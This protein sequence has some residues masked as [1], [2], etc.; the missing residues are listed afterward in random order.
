MGKRKEIDVSGESKKAKKPVKY[1]ESNIEVLKGLEVVRAKPGMYM[2]ERG[3]P[4]VYRS[5]KEI[6][7]NCFD[8]FAAGRNKLIEVIFDTN[9]NVYYVADQAGGIPVGMHKTEKKSA[10]EVIFTQLHAGGKF[11][12]KAYKTSSGTHG[13]GAAATNALS[14]EFQVWTQRE[15]QWYTQAYA[16]GIPQH[17]VK[18]CKAPKIVHDGH[19]LDD[20]IGKYGSIVRFVPDQTIVSESATDKKSKNLVTAKLNMKGA[21]VWL[22]NLALLNP[23]L[24]IRV[25]A[26]G[27]KTRKFTFLNKEGLPAIVKKIAEENELSLTG[28]P[29]VYQSETIDCVLQWSSHTDNDLLKTYVNC[30]PTRDHGKHFDGLSS[31]LNKSLNEYKGARDKFKIVDVLNGV[32]GS[33]NYKMSGAEYSSQTKD[34]LTSL[35]NKEIEEELLPHLSAY[36][37]ANKTMVKGIIKR[38]NEINKGRAQ[39]KDVMAAIAGVKKG[40]SKN[41]DINLSAFLT[42]ASR[43]KPHERELY[44]VEGDSAAGPSKEARD[45]KF[46]EVFKL[47]GKMA[48][49]IRT[50]L[51]K[52]ISSKAIILLL[53]AIGVDTRKID[54]EQD[55]SK[56]HF[57]TDKLRVGK[58]MLLADADVD[59]K[60]IN[61][62]LLCL[63]WRLVPDAIREGRV[64]IVDAPLYSA[65]YNNVRYFGATFDAVSKQMPDRAP[66]NIISRAKGWG[67]IDSE[68]LRFVA[69][70]PKNRK[71]IKIMPPKDGDGESYFKSIMGEN[72]QVRKEL[73]GIAA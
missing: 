37:E 44:I 55:I 64:F 52:L 16:K 54:L 13:V 25:T 15:G 67:E 39:L 40:G 34:R 48:N 63:I 30:S 17:K 9:K 14:D 5:V 18:E 69:F 31:A 73:L 10:L 21:L 27:K 66:R 58:I 50:D 26:I 68:M 22:S 33:F 3:D 32:I 43:C 46:Q 36:F 35:V 42:S 65:F 53:Q 24:T 47:T 41:S 45:P 28:K 70:D 23:G 62:L 49:A 57:T 4:M 38:A 2:G 19:T 72:T 20:K 56:I 71:L 29:F 60:H 51:A 8:E 6:V 11:N 12:S 1:D 61:C 59:G 7:D